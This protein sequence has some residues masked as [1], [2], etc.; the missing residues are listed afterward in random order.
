MEGHTEAQGGYEPS[1]SLTPS[2]KPSQGFWWGQE[3]LER[4]REGRLPGG[5]GAGSAPWRPCT[6]HPR[7]LSVPHVFPQSRHMESLG[8]SHEALKSQLIRLED[9]QGQLTQ[10]ISHLPVTKLRSREE[11]ECPSSHSMRWKARVGAQG[12]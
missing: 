12:S 7:L 10:V 9:P 6:P 1:H 8:A 11:L 3:V 5:G 4:L 2:L